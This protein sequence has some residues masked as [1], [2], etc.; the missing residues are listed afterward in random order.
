MSVVLLIL[1]IIGIILLILLGILLLAVLSVLLIPARYRLAGE[2]REKA[3]FRVKVGWF[4]S[5]FSFRVEYDGE[6]KQKFCILGIPIRLPTGRTAKRTEGSL[7]AQQLSEAS[8]AGEEA[9]ETEKAFANAAA[10]GMQK[11]NGSEEAFIRELEAG[12]QKKAQAKEPSKNV[13]PQE[14]AEGLPED[15]R[16]QEKAGKLP[17]D[18]ALQAA[19][20]SG[21]G[22]DHIEANPRAE[23]SREEIFE[24][25]EETVESPKETVESSKE[26]FSEASASSPRRKKRSFRFF[27]KLKHF[28][29]MIKTKWE[30]LKETPRRLQRKYRQLQA[31]SQSLKENAR[32]GLTELKR[33]ENRKGAAAVF[34][35][36]KYLLKHVSPRKIKGEIAFGTDDPALTGQI[37][38]GISI[39]PFFYRYQ[40]SVT[41]DFASERY[42]LE[43][44]LEMKGHARM[45]HVLVSGFRLIRDRNIR[46][47]I[48]R[49]RNS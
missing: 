47:L 29:G 12:F 7:M 19:E 17:E 9:Q 20:L 21:L 28:F 48:R 43:G 34:R 4:F 41:P 38:G 23:E 18:A 46:R 2:F 30:T 42:Y 10:E 40:I 45:V 16:L 32:R 25:P 39:L 14:K 37:L 8:E 1:K 15:V 35:E 49:F 27:R 31:K 26:P 3:A 33:E 11:E 44:K 36:L 22:H 6:L 13:Q 5:V 24:L